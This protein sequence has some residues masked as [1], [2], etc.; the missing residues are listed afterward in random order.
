MD[1]FQRAFGRERIVNTK[2][3][4]FSNL[5]RGLG[6]GYIVYYR[7]ADNDYLRGD[8]QSALTN[9]NKTIEKSDIYD[10]KHFAFRANL[11]ED[12]KNYQ[13]AITDYQQ[14][15]EYAQSDIDVYALYHQIGFCHLN[16]NNNKK[17][18]EF[19]TYAIELKKQH[20]NSEFDTDREGM[21]G[22]V[23][24]GIP[25]KRMYNNRGDALMNLGK[26]NEALEDCEISI[27]YDKQY[28]NPYLLIA[29]IFSKTGQEQE[30]M[31]FLKAAAQLGNK[32]AISIIEQLSKEA[33]REEVSDKLELNFVFHSSDHLR[34]ENG[35]HVAGPHGGAS[36]AL[37]VEAN[38]G[39]GV[40]YTVTMFNTDDGQARVQ[41]APKQ[42]KLIQADREKISLRGYG[43][44][45]MANPFSDYGITIFHDNGNIIKCVLH[46]FD[47]NINIEYLK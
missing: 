18:L 2:K 28:S 20:P 21:D 3:R 41:M 30:A 7:A 43:A 26:F 10:W 12:L 45:Q 14:A 39:G 32:N 31:N 13:L 19:Y 11:N 23:M 40:G 47:R 22:G 15:I 9:I 6:S 42:M 17:A 27:S 25:F 8:I 29:N 34:F 46:M 5:F 24:L 36:R 33:C 38:I 16:L 4:T 44:D 35:V 37:K 1:T